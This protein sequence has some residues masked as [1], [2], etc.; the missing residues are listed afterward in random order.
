MRYLISI[1]DLYFIGIFNDYNK[2]NKSRIYKTFTCIGSKALF[3]RQML[4]IYFYIIRFNGAE[5][6]ITW[7]ML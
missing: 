3:N 2:G 4:D 7:D 5:D 1:H 6:K